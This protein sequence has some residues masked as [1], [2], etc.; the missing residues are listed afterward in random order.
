MPPLATKPPLGSRDEHS[1]EEKRL[2]DLV[3]KRWGAA[4]KLHQQYRP[5]WDQF[6][7][8]SRNWRRQKKALTQASTENDRD[9]VIDELKR[10]WG[11]ELFIPYCHTVIE[12][13][14]P[15]IL[16]RDVQYRA[17]PGDLSD[18]AHEAAEP[19]ERL[20]ER[21]AKA[22]SYTRKLQESA[23]SGLRYGLGVHKDYW[24]CRTRKGK[25]IAGY[26]TKA[27]YQVR[28]KRI[29]VYEGPQNESVDIF[30]FRW[31]PSGHDLETCD[32]VIH[33]TWRSID[34]IV[35]RV[36]EG[37]KNRAQGINRGW[38]ELDIERIKKLSS[39]DGRAKVWAGRNEASGLS[40]NAAEEELFE[41][42]EC[43]D[44]EQVLVV[45]GGESGILVEQNGNPFIHG[46]FPF[47]IFRPTIVEHEFVGIGEI[48]PI[49]HLQWELNTL[50]GQRRDAATLALNQGYFYQEGTLDP[51]QIALGPGMMNPVWGNPSEIMQPMNFRDIPQ[52][53][54]SEE[55]AIKADIELATGISE[56]VTGTGGEETATGTQ[57]VQA[58]AN[59]RIKQKA[60]N[61][62]V[63]LVRPETAHRE[64]LYEQYVVAQGQS[65]TVRVED[66]TTPTG[67]R[68]IQVSPEMF[69]ANVEVVPVDGSTEA[70]DPAQKKH[71]AGELG[72]LLAPFAEQLNVPEFLKYAL[73]QHDI[74]GVE[75][76]VKEGPSPA[77]VGSQTAQSVAQKFNEA[78]ERAGLPEQLI[79]QILEAAH[80]N[81]D[82]EQS[83]EG[84][85]PGAAPESEPP[86]SSNGAAPEP[87]GA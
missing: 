67:Y 3:C 55:Q 68:F 25:S 19:L 69:L 23:R 87:I 47:A 38:R 70:D 73:R 76:W 40:S 5:K 63:D 6:Y 28:D 30:N 84:P 32:Y 58:A 64:S 46:D 33:R 45:L 54:I 26:D 29:T 2:L 75:K 37:T 17:L 12:T 41:V 65:Q 66:A 43:H 50:R 13:V 71:D 44:R 51:T 14:L 8:L 20:Y 36:A 7:G 16:S 80:S 78:M 56:A 31:D 57:L 27:G 24:E 53:G 48:E 49:A 60:K 10:Q 81:L 18:A 72:M 77:Q 42:W 86:A 74:E 22:M 61:L 85:P 15:R 35:D 52:S 9:V 11:Q 1:A 39:G 82:T 34:Y 4:E 79:Q 83:Q 59:L 21:D 62:F